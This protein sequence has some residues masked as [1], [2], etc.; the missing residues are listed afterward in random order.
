MQHEIMHNVQ[1]NTWFL[2]SAEPNCWVNFAERSAEP[3]LYPQNLATARNLF[4]RST[5]YS[6]V[7]NAV[8]NLIE[9][10]EFW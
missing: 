8:L 7:L 9:K 4:G 1:A 5:E 2:G 6:L 10:E 3:N